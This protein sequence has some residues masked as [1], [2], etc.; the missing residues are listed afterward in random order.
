MSKLNE[1]VIQ[2]IFFFFCANSREAVKFFL[3][4]FLFNIY[5]FNTGSNYSHFSIFL[6]WWL[7]MLFIVLEVFF[8]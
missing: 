2:R 5:L 1:N 6:L 4:T 7:R 8:Y 3:Y